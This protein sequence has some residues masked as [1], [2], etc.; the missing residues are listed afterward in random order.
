MALGGVGVFQVGTGWEGGVWDSGIL[1][2]CALFQVGTG[3][4]GRQAAPKPRHGGL[5]PLIESLRAD[6]WHGWPH[7]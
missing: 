1:V 5:L 2:F 7:P 4:A 3:R 6:H